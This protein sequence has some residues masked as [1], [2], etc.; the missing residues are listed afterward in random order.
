[1]HSATPGGPSE[2]PDNHP[3]KLVELEFIDDQFNQMKQTNFALY[4]YLNNIWKEKNY[5]FPITF[6]PF[7]YLDGECTID[8]NKNG[9]FRAKYAPFWYPFGI[10]RS[11]S[12]NEISKYYPRMKGGYYLENN[13]IAK[14]SSEVADISTSE[15]PGYIFI[16]RNYTERD[17][18]L[19]NNR[20]T[21]QLP[22]KLDPAKCTSGFTQLLTWNSF[23]YNV[24]TT[25]LFI[26]KYSNNI[27]IK[28]YPTNSIHLS[29]DYKYIFDANYNLIPYDECYLCIKYIENNLFISGVQVQTSLGLGKINYLLCNIY[30]RKYVDKVLVTIGETFFV[31]DSSSLKIV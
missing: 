27:S 7:Y 28:L 24:H 20:W 14:K 17:R 5:K 16:T 21:Y 4:R 26:K 25:M 8:K 29:D 10:T 1:M 2:G 11:V 19:Y 13:E 30:D 15:T 31:F 3:L 9:E 22:A 23:I 12:L 6:T 18:Y